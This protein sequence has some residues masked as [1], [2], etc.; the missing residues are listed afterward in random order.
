MQTSN[1]AHNLLFN[2]AQS[3]VNSATSIVEIRQVLSGVEGKATGQSVDPIVWIND[4][5]SDLC[6]WCYF[7][8]G[9]IVVIQI[10]TGL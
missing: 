7:F 9:I 8:G 1:T 5:K 2:G 3:T 10:V 6:V 4:R